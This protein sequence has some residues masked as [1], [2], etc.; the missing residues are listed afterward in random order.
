MEM[1]NDEFYIL[2]GEKGMLKAGLGSMLSNTLA[3]SEK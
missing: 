2:N 3:A 1:L